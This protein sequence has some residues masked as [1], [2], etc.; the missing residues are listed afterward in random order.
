M[1][2]DLSGIKNISVFIEKVGHPTRH[3]VVLIS[4]HA[5]TLLHKERRIDGV[6]IPFSNITES[7]TLET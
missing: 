5:R 3:A 2:I 6:V 7:K 1:S 4:N